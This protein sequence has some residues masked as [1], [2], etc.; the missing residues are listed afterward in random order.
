MKEVYLKGNRKS[1]AD[2]PLMAER[3][4]M[5]FLKTGYSE[6]LVPAFEMLEW[7]LKSILRVEIFEAVKSRT[8]QSKKLEVEI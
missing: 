3:K 4:E 8:R 6:R 1:F 5:I 7:K 2:L